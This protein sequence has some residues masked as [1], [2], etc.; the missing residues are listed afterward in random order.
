MMTTSMRAG[1]GDGEIEAKTLII[2]E[3]R[4]RNWTRYFP[5]FSLLISNQSLKKKKSLLY[6]KISEG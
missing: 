3:K 2:S 5:V 1:L 4:R 6:M